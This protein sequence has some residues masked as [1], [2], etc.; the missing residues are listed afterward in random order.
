VFRTRSPV[1]LAG[2]LDLHVLSTP[3]AFVLSQD[4]TLQEEFKS[5]PTNSTDL[6]PRQRSPESCNDQSSISRA[7]LC[8][9]SLKRDRLAHST[10]LDS[11]VNQRPTI[12]AGVSKDTQRSRVRQSPPAI[13]PSVLPQRGVRGDAKVGRFQA[14]C[15]QTE[16]RET[17]A[18][19]ARQ[20]RREHP[21]TTHT[22]RATR[23]PPRDTPVDEPR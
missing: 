6:F 19:P 20:A 16:P 23:P 10:S 5:A 11:I 14:G 2:P 21:L 17:A 8:T 15:K 12:S 22:P 4:Q 1:A 3:P 7:V 18:I 13:A 9:P